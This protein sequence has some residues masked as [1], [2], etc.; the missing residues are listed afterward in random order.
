M[1]NRKQFLIMVTRYLGH[2]IEFDLIF[3]SYTHTNTYVHSKERQYLCRTRKLEFKI[4][5]IVYLAQKSYV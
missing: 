2:F 4:A 3:Y 5:E 1:S